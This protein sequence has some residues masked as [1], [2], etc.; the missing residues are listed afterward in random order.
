MTSPAT[1][2]WLGLMFGAL[3]TTILRNR[4]E[5]CE[6]KRELAPKTIEQWAD[7]MFNSSICAEE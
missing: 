6:I 4:R 7:K 1:G 3:F 2:F 5:I